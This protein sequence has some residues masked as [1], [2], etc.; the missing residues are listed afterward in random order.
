MQ[1]TQHLRVEQ[2]QGSDRRVVL[3]GAVSVQQARIVR[4]AFAELLQLSGDVII[5]CVEVKQ[6]D[7]SIYQLL[8]VMREELAAQQRKMVI[9]NAS[10]ELQSHFCMVGLSKVLTFS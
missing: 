9:R 3:P 5:D 1:S 6:P 7:A 10:E 4:D 2:E 8:L